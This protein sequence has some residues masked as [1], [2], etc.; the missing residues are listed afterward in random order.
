MSNAKEE[1][2]LFEPNSHHRLIKQEMFTK[3]NEAKKMLFYIL[4]PVWP[5]VQYCEIRIQ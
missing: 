3:Q 2:I 5:V 1:N 4:L